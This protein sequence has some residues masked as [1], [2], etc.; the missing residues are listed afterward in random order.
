M[1]WLKGVSVP[2]TSACHAK[3]CLAAV[4]LMLKFQKKRLKS[5]MKG[6]CNVNCKIKLC[7]KLI[8][9]EIAMKLMHYVIDLHPLQRK[10]K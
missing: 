4:L 1:E 2:V 8:P 6:L 10:K 5:D 7:T 9:D 3:G